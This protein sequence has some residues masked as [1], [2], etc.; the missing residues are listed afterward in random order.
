MQ[1]PAMNVTFSE[2]PKSRTRRGLIWLD[3]ARRGVAA[4]LGLLLKDVFGRTSSQMA[5]EPFPH[6]FA[7]AACYRMLFAPLVIAMIAACLV[8]RGT[9]GPT[10]A[11]AIDPTCQGMPYDSVNFL[12]RRARGA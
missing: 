11:A 10:I 9:H 7:R 4:G 8:Y 2:P 12:G 6:R 5:T 1:R 3:M